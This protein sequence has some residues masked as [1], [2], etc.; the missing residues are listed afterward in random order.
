[1][2]NDELEWV[3]V[4]AE[5]EPWCASEFLE[6]SPLKGKTLVLHK[7]IYGPGVIGMGREC[8]HFKWVWSN[9]EYQ[10]GDN[11]RWEACG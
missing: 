4:I 7:S 2:A 8:R 9:K 5:L 11:G 1:M 10:I 6:A 3:A